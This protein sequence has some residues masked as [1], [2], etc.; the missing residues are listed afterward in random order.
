MPLDA[1]GNPEQGRVVPVTSRNLAKVERQVERGR[2]VV[3]GLVPGTEVP[4]AEGPMGEVESKVMEDMGLEPE[5]F[6]IVGLTEL[7]SPGIRRPL[8]IPGQDVS[9]HGADGRVIFSFRLQKGTYATC[10]LREL[11]KAPLL[12]Y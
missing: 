10:V 4:S 6:R 1:V 2:A 8:A 9:W 3:S 11:M 7:T 5:M 12:S